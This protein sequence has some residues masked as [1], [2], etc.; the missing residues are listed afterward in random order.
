MI[1]IAEI[2]NGFGGAEVSAVVNAAISLV[3]HECLQKFP[4]LEEAANH[5][6]DAVVSSQYFEEAVRK[7]KKQRETKPGETISSMVSY[8]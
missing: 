1:K 3:L 4:S 5:T 6:S 8:R 7:I 2:T